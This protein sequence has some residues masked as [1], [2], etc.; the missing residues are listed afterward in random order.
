MNLIFIH[1]GNKKITYI[2][3]SI[4]Q[5]LKFNKGLKIILI[6]NKNT[7]NCLSPK[8][9]KNIIFEDTSKIILKKNHKNFIRNSLLDKDWYDGF[10]RYTS[11]RFFYLQNIAQKRKLKN[12]FHIENDLMVYFN[13]KSKLKIF[14]KNYNI[15]LLLDS[16]IKAIPS[17]LYFKNIKY[18]NKFVDFFEK[19]HSLSNKIFGKT[20]GKF[21]QRI[22]NSNF[23][24]NNDMDILLKFYN[25]FKKNKKIN[26]LPSATPALKKNKEQTKNINIAL[27]Y[28]KFGGIFDP[29]N[30][31]LYLD[32][33]DRNKIFAKE[34]VKKE[35]FI[36][37]SA[38][39]V[40]KYK[41]KFLRIGNYKI[42]FLFGNIK[43]VKLLTLHIHSK[44]LN[45][46][47]S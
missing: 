17:L 27:H 6:S 30:F 21:S 43:P 45:R 29:A 41:I 5:V 8:M 23:Y 11:E 36:S 33:F 39:D 4:R 22:F 9:R 26:I 40:K 46:F 10:W 32:G 44:R 47:L 38:V 37:K 13:I 25:K 2:K 16:N 14:E 42:P 24:I 34:K 19:N 15:G 35:K 12:I 28:K 31:G 18:I 3:D 1:I 20:L 7:F